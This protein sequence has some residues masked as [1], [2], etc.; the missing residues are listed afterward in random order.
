MQEPGQH[1]IALFSCSTD[2]FGHDPFVYEHW[3]VLIVSGRSEMFSDERIVSYPQGTLGL[4]RKNQL[5]KTT[6]KADGEKPFKS[7]SIC[8]DQQT[9]KK[10]SAEYGVKAEGIYTGE[11]FVLLE[12]DVFMRSYFNSIMPYFAQPEKLTPVL[13]QIKT[14][15]AIV[16]LLRNAA[17]KNF[18]FDFS[19]PHKID[20]EA[21]MNR[22]FSYNVPVTQFA[23]LTGR[24]ISSFKRDFAKIFN[25]TPEKWLQ[26]RRLE[27]AYFLIAQKNRKPSEVYLEVGFENLSHFSRIFKKEFGVNASRL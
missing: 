24:S 26:K 1:N 14:T 10:F 20:L 4:I 25:T 19:E 23:K 21:Y 3:L 17:L 11:P 2:E 8:I 15:E 6:K 27:M 5:I 13:A 12:N 7:I 22:Y 16:L 18:L 9:L